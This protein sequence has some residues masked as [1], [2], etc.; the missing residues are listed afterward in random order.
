MG[1]I[2]VNTKRMPIWL[3]RILIIGGVGYILSA[4]LKYVGIDAAIADSLAIPATIGE[5]WMIGY[6]LSYGIRAEK[7]SD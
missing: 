2:V 3:G 1:Y 4:F 6:L 7:A 5:F